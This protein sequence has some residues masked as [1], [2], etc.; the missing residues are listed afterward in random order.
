MPLSAASGNGVSIERPSPKL[1]SAKR[2]L[3]IANEMELAHYAALDSAY[4]GQKSPIA[5]CP[6]CCRSPNLREAA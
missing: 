1:P 2:E 6:I 3:M 5:S 4:G